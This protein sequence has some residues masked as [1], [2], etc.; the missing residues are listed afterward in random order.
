MHEVPAER[1]IAVCHAPL[2]PSGDFVLYWMLAAHRIGWNFGLQ[3]AVEWGREL[4]KPLVVLETLL[5]GRSWDADR[6]HRFALEGMTDN[7]RLLRQRNICAYPFVEERPGQ[8]GELVAA[9]AQ[10]ACAVVVDDCPAHVYAAEV[11]T[12]GRGLEVCCEAVDS[13]GLLPLRAA[14]RVFPTAHA[15]RRFLQRELKPHLRQMPQS[16]PLRGQRLPGPATLPA[17]IVGR[18]PPASEALLAGD[19]SA[20]A[21]LPLDHSVGPV[22]I[23][24]GPVAAG[25]TL[26]RFV[27]D[28]LPFYA[29][30]RAHPDRDGTSGLSAYLHWGHISAH[31]VFSEVMRAQGWGVE[32]LAARAT[33]ARSGWWGVD[34]NAESFLD[35]LITWRELGYNMAWQVEG[36]DR[37]ETLPRWALDTL[38]RHARDER[39]YLY[40]LEEL[41]LA[42]TH[43][44]LWNAAQ[45]QLVR[46]G[47]VHNTLRMLWGKKILEWSPTPQEA[48]RVMI[49]LNNRY[50][51]DGRNP[52]SYSGILW[53]LGRYDRAWGPERPVFGTV[54]Y[55]SSTNTA[56]KVRVREYIRRFAQ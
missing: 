43:D 1:I 5:S 35:E 42:H 12:V 40:T 44:A 26:R 38:E 50:G 41:E 49:E 23:R 9:L 47:R 13:N 6:H 2:R 15:F 20:L 25:A 22:A 48:L 8:A 39:P 16:D 7:L 53:C 3:R 56:R 31:Q 29:E 17:D 19:A 51:L 10:H 33:G 32:C 36:Y 18:Y 55:M 30:A 52:N 11:Q 27:E 46:E 28:K 24:G 21:Q 37:Y 54:R 34:A 14:E 4:G 45:R